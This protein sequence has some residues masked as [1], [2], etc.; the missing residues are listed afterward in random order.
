[1]SVGACVELAVQISLVLYRH[2]HNSITT[3]SVSLPDI[4]EHVEHLWGE[5][6]VGHIKFSKVR[7]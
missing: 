4:F 1:M 2:V 6:G 3:K 7:L 5:V